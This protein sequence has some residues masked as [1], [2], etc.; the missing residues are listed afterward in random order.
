VLVFLFLSAFVRH[1]IL[2]I[3]T[4]VVIVWLM[5]SVQTT[6]CPLVALLTACGSSALSCVVEHLMTTTVLRQ[7][8]HV[9]QDAVAADAPRTD[10]LS[11]P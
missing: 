3:L 5:L 7:P 6:P 8:P 1:R 9:A 10:R 4:I 2:A 11:R